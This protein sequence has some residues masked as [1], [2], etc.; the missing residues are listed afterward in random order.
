M[1]KYYSC[2]GDS[3]DFVPI[4]NDSLVYDDIVDRSSF[5][6]DSES[7]RQSILSSSAGSDAGDLQYDKSDNMPSDVV[8][9]IRQGKLDKAEIHQLQLHLQDDIE[10]DEK[11]AEIESINK[12]RLENLDKLTGFDVANSVKNT[13]NVN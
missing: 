3:I 9:A 7:V 1:I 13:N 11:Q 8:V 6:L 4:S 2:F 10:N 12:A 5:V